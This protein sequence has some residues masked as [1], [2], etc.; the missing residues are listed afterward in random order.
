MSGEYGI[1][2][3]RYSTLLQNT[4]ISTGYANSVLNGQGGIQDA[5]EKSTITV[6]IDGRQVKTTY[7]DGRRGLFIRYRDGIQSLFSNSKVIGVEFRLNSISSIVNLRK[8][9]N[10]YSRLSIPLMTYQKNISKFDETKLLSSIS[11]FIDD[12]QLLETI[13]DDQ[14]N[15]FLLPEISDPLERKMILLWAYFKTKSF[16]GF[17]KYQ[18]SG[19]LPSPLNPP[20][21]KSLVVMDGELGKIFHTTEGGSS[22]LL[23]DAFASFHQTPPV[24]SLPW[25]SRTLV[26]E[27]VGIIEKTFAK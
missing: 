21:S 24:N 20:V 8:T 26:D 6:G 17:E 16:W 18:I 22:R 3:D 9:L 13:Q 11:E 2:L 1:R 7:D 19:I 27:V 12:S 14:N 15:F 23:D 5:E 4:L 10:A 25:F